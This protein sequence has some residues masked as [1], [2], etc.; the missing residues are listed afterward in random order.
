MGS[1]SSTLR[2]NSP[3]HIAAG[4]KLGLCS[5]LR[6]FSHCMN[7]TQFTGAVGLDMTQ[8][9]LAI[10]DGKVERKNVPVNSPC[11]FHWL[12]NACGCSQTSRGKRK[13]KC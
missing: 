10:P 12:Q 2:T 11:S 3:I 9:F 5:V 1:L 13:I 8:S 7:L 6:A 4:T